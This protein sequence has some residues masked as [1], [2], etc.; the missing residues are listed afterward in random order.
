M[1]ASNMAMAALKEQGWNYSDSGWFFERYNYPR[2]TAP[3]ETG[4]VILDICA[5]LI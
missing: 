2:F 3:D 4:N 5:C 1:K